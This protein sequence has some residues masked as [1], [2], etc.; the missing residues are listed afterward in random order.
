[1]KILA[2]IEI[3]F[4]LIKFEHVPETNIVVQQIK[5]PLLG[6]NTNNVAR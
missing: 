2:N 1:M 4:T 5:I 3:N 6:P